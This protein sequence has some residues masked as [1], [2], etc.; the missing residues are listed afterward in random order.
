VLANIP[1]FFPFL[2][3]SLQLPVWGQNKEVKMYM[4]GVWGWNL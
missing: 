3:L 4:V 1:L 2:F